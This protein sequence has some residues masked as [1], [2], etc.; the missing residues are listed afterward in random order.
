MESGFVTSDEDNCGYEDYIFAVRKKWL[1]DY[2][3]IVADH[4]VTEDWLDN[5][6]LNEY[7]G[8]DSYEVYMAAEAQGEII[9][10]GP[11]YPKG[12]V[13]RCLYTV[14][15]YLRNDG[16]DEDKVYL[17]TTNKEEALKRFDKEVEKVKKEIARGE[18]FL[19]DVDGE[20]RTRISD[21]LPALEFNDEDGDYYDLHVERTEFSDWRR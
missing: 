21:G 16:E 20:I 12:K 6:L 19:Q 4:E 2:M 18:F 11:I 10:E 17:Q 15:E 13:C 1:L 9:F 8:D 3:N 14:K 7:T 5:W